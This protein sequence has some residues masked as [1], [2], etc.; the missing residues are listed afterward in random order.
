ML[1]F[2]E[3]KLSFKNSK[4]VHDHS[5]Q[6][7]RVARI[8]GQVA[9]IERMIDE[10]RY[11]PEIIQQVKAVR[12]ALKGLETKIFEAHLKGCVRKALNSKSVIESNQKIDELVELVR[13]QN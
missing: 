6:K 9:A 1:K 3:E 11:C 13:N 2:T 5:A 4:K 10:G 12:S 8:K 7:K